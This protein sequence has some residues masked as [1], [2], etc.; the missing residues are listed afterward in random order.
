VMSACGF[1]ADLGF[2][3][4]HPRDPHPR[5]HLVLCMVTLSHRKASV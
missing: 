3:V 1:E 2:F 5:Q 4:W